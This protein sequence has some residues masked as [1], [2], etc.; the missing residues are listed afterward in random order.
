[1]FR[2]GRFYFCK[3]QTLFVAIT[4]G[5]LLT[6]ASGAGPYLINAQQ[7]GFWNRP[8]YIRDHFAHIET[9]PFDGLTISTTAGSAIM[10]GE[11]RSYAEIA[12]DFAPLNGLSFT[13]MKHN[14]ALVNVDRPADFFGDWA[15]TI[16]NFRML[17][18]V[19]KEK[20]IEGIFFDNEEYRRPLFNYPEDCNDRSKSLQEYQDQARL[21]GRQ[22]METMAAEY[23][24]I[25]FMAFHG[26]Y[27]SC[28]GTPDNVR[29][30][31]TNWRLEELR[32]PF[33]V[34]LIEGMAS[35]SRFVDGGEVYAYRTVDDF[36]V[37]YDFRK[38]RIAS[39]E[40]DCPF[41][42]N[43][44]R[45]AWP[46]KVSIAF[47]VYNYP[48]A[49]Q[50]MTPAILRTT[51]ERALTRCDDYVWLYFE[52]ENWNAPGEI[53]QSWVD[54]VVAPKAAAAKPPTSPPPSVSITNPKVGSVFNR[55]VIIP[56][57]ANASVV[58]RSITKVEFFDGAERLGEAVRTPYSFSWVGAAVGPHTL[59]AKATDNRGATTTSSRVPITVSAGFL[60][61]I[62]FQIAG[63]TP[64]IGYF[65]DNGEVYGSRGNGLT[66]GWNISHGA[67]ARNRGG[68]ADLRLSTLCQFQSGGVWQLAVPNGVYN[69]TVGI[70]DGGY[71]STY[72]INVEGVNYWNAQSL[73]AGQ[74]INRTR[75]VNVS[76]GNLTIDQGTGGFEETRINYVL[77]AAA[78]APP[79]APTGLTA[80]MLSTN[81]VDLNW[82]NNS[83]VGAGFKLERSTSA[84]FAV[85]TEIGSVGIYA[86]S[87]RDASASRGITYYY[88]VRAFNAAGTSANSNAASAT[89]P[90][91]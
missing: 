41:I 78:I 70:G 48:F 23:P 71:P 8:E 9:L 66:Y 32:G 25:V 3:I 53:A 61:N 87:F 36:Q 57:T 77:V 22:I 44:L 6:K 86:T 81:T 4:L 24:E 16:E 2:A 13:R 69:V 62:N 59:T 85:A 90:E 30:G 65:A 52:K 54:A 73:S 67:N 21:R 35:R 40:T 75:V 64:P 51:L 11:T 84:D 91:R 37:S 43:F 58:D 12:S 7:S 74:F 39:S 63:V 26:P 14:F 56:I 33:S 42:S 34:G 72:T 88:R 55:A 46:L 10:S 47:G 82:A 45:P 18:K 19:L 28:S 68:S 29:R 89:L 50:A 49:G 1:M 79:A 76:N 27:S 83:S 15:V 17:A 60:A 80:N 38:Y 20:G 5:V 31:Q